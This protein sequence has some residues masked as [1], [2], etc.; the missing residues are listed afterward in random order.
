MDLTDLSECLD[1]LDLR[2]GYELEDRLDYWDPSDL[3]DPDGASI[4]KFLSFSTM[5]FW[6][7]ATLGL[8]SLKVY[9][10]YYCSSLNSVPCLPWALVPRERGNMGRAGGVILARPLGRGFKTSL[11]RQLSIF[12]PLEG[13]APPAVLGGP[14]W[15]EFWLS[16]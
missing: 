12:A 4:Y 5:K 7:W 10:P 16:W 8:I 11:D 15:V 6:L 9:P 13:W 14:L 3:S 2:E 1:W